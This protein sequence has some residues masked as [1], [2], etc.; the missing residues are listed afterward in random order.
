MPMDKGFSALWFIAGMTKKVRTAKRTRALNGEHYGGRAPYGYIKDPA[1]RHRLIIDGEAA[2]VVNR[3]FRMAA[4]GIGVYRISRHLFDERIL[5]P[6]AAEYQRS[7]ILQSKFDPD[8]PWDWSD[9]TVSGILRNPVYLGHMVNQ[10]MRSKSFKLQKL[11]RLPEEEWIV[12]EN[13]HEPIVSRQL[14]DRVQLLV[15]V[16]HREHENASKN[17]FT[18]VLVCADCGKNLRY[19]SCP[20]MRGG[21]GAFNCATYRT[22][23]RK[24]TENHCTSHH[25]GYTALREAIT[26]NIN[27]AIQVSLNHERFFELINAGRKDH[28]EADK[29]EFARLKRR[30]GEL[31]NLIK[32]AFEQNAYGLLTDEMFRSICEGYQEDHKKLCEDIK[33]LEG[34]LAAATQENDNAEQFLQLAEQHIKVKELTRKTLLDFIEKIVIHEATGKPHSKDRRRVIEIHYRFIGK[35]SGKQSL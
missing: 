25:I 3:M 33:L 35:L 18:G 4:D 6:S 11:V 15:A 22:G 17:I 30:E 23:N 19:L 12:I 8:C 28:S 10:R 7:G 27:L 16:K 2:D 29:K 31:R 21:E 9:K 34:R 32:R 13:T 20:G 1:N 14:F 24:G 5:I 26:S